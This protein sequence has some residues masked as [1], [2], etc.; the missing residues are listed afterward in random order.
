MC[1]TYVGG[2]GTIPN[3][4]RTFPEPP[5]L[6]SGQQQ[7]QRAPANRRR[8]LH[9]PACDEHLPQCIQRDDTFMAEQHP[10]FPGER[11]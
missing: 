10:I 3:L 5:G 1:M 2:A 11:S 7:L 4:A 8:P 9:E 6:D